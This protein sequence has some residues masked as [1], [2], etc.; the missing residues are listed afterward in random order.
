MTRS[1]GAPNAPRPAREEGAARLEPHDQALV[2]DRRAGNA[3][4]KAIKAK[5]GGREAADPVRRDQFAETARR[6]LDE[7]VEL[8]AQAERLRRDPQ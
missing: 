4:Q 3:L 7:A 8:M 2:L 1:G 6:C 5:Q